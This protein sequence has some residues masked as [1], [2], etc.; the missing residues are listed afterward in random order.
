VCLHGGDPNTSDS[1]DCI[2]LVKKK[3]AKR[4]KKRRRAR[5]NFNDHGPQL[6]LWRPLRHRFVP[7]AREQLRAQEI[8]IF[9][10]LESS[11]SSSLKGSDYWEYVEKARTYQKQY[12]AAGNTH[13]DVVHRE[14]IDLDEWVSELDKDYIHTQDVLARNLV[15]NSLSKGIPTVIDLLDE[16]PLPSGRQDGAQQVAATHCTV[17]PGDP[18]SGRQG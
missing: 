8:D 17:T 1:D 12:D 4:L 11:D 9:G 13:L 2:S 7:K 16:D 18:P 15:F 6:N 10:P 14:Q 3:P 5:R